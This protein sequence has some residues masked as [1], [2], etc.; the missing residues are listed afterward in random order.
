MKRY[1]KITS[2]PLIVLGCGLLTCLLRFWLFAMGEDE[3]G[4]LSVGTFP[5]AM[6]WITVALTL[7]LLAFSCRDLNGGN[8]YSFNF[9][10]SVQAAAG[11]ALAAVGFCISSIADLAANTDALGKFSAFFGFLAAFAML[12]LAYARYKGQRLNIL[13]SGTVCV[14]LMAFLVSH[15]RLWSANP[16]LQTYGFELLAIVFVMLAA[17][18]RAA[19][20]AGKGDRRWYAFFSL[21]ALFFCIATLPGCDNAAFF[22][23]CAAWMFCTPCKLAIAKKEN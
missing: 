17:Y 6:S 9:P 23:G 16:Q 2:L 14:Y 5:D 10:A 13:F 15:Y 1:L 11:M 7:A 21:A 20:D 4:L 19:F 22:L 8:K 3:R 12:M 18:Q